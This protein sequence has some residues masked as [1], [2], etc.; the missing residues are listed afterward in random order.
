MKE[1][2]IKVFYNGLGDH[3]LHS[4]LPRLAKQKWGYNR[5]FI[6]NHSNYS[7]PSIKRIVWEMNPFVDGFSDGDHDYPTFGSV[8]P[9]ANILDAVSMFYELDDGER[10]REPEVYYKSKT[11]QSIRECVVFEPNHNNAYG[12]PTPEQTEAYFAKQGIIITHQ[13]KPLHGKSSPGCRP[14]LTAHS[15]E[16]FCDVIHS[17]RAFYCYTSGA[18]TLAAALGKPVTV[19]FVE[20]INPMFHHS[21][22]HSYVKL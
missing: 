22:L 4:H 6:S 12:I 21:K 11:M 3:L 5:V 1:L 14:E 17:C 16:D 7:N 9:G 13:M 8:P 2:I 18:A 19:L 10:F 15:L 20:G